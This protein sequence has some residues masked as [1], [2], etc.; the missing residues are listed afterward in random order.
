MTYTCKDITDMNNN[1]VNIIIEIDLYIK[2]GEDG[3]PR[4]LSGKE[5]Q[6]SWTANLPQ[7]NDKSKYTIKDYLAKDGDQFFANNGIAFRLGWINHNDT[8]GITLAQDPRFSKWED[9][10]SGKEAEALNELVQKFSEYL[11]YEPGRGGDAG[12]KQE[13][14]IDASTQTTSVSTSFNITYSDMFNLAESFMG[15]LSYLN[16]HRF[17]KPEQKTK[18]QFY[19]LS[20]N[21]WGDGVTINPVAKLNEFVDNT[22]K[23][24]KEYNDFT[25][26]AKSSVSIN[27]MP[28]TEDC[29]YKTVL[30]YNRYKMLTEVNPLYEAT[31]ILSFD[32]FGNVDK[33]INKGVTKICK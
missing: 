11:K 3:K 22:L 9:I 26:L 19:V 8:K 33:V 18:E 30:P 25:K 15:T 6:D 32:M 7:K 4:M 23:N 21:A 14:P 13:Q 20:E 1:P 29:S 5:F 31:V 28:I 24:C 17:I 27:F 10:A 2:K 12:K 16:V